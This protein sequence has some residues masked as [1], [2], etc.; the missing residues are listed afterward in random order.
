MAFKIY[1]DR[2]CFLKRANIDGGK[3]TKLY[4]KDTPNSLGAKLVCIDA[5]FTLDNITF[6][7]KGC[8]NKFIK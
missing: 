1:T 6:E 5:R 7:G 2:E 4:Q 8:I 3:Y